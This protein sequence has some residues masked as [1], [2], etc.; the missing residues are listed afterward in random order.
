MSG[1][2]SISKR[3]SSLT[4]GVIYFHARRLSPSVLFRIFWEFQSW[5]GI[6]V[7]LYLNK[8]IS[9]FIWEEIFSRL[10]NPVVG[11]V[12][13]ISVSVAEIIKSRWLLIS[14]LDI[15]VLLIMRSQMP[16]SYNNSQCSDRKPWL[17]LENGPVL[18]FAF[19]RIHF[20]LQYLNI[21]LNLIL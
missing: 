11:L 19:P 13:P 5:I 7:L 2:T 9:K 10:I 4:M 14:I 12:T 21:F 17:N 15:K 20:I 16:S 8:K 18:I 1:I 6:Q 3:K